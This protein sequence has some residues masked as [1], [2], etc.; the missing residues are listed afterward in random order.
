M[1]GQFT[2]KNGGNM[3][4]HSDK[5]SDKNRRPNSY[6][7]GQG[8]RGSRNQ[9][10]GLAGKAN[11]VS[12]DEVDTSK[13]NPEEKLR[14]FNKLGLLNPT[15]K[16]QLADIDAKKAKSSTANVEPVHKPSTEQPKPDV[17]PVKELSDKLGKIFANKPQLI[18][19]IVK[20][21]QSVP[22]EQLKDKAQ[23]V[24]KAMNNNTSTEPTEVF[25]TVM[26]AIEG[27]PEK[28]EDDIDFDEKEPVK[29][30]PEEG[31]IDWIRKIHK[32]VF[33]KYFNQDFDSYKSYRDLLKNKHD[34]NIF[35]DYLEKMEKNPKIKPLYDLAMNKLNDFDP[36]E[37]EDSKF[38]NIGDAVFSIIKDGENVQQS[39]GTEESDKYA[40][41]Y[42]REEE[43]SR[44]L[45]RQY[46][47][48]S[49]NDFRKDFHFLDSKDVEALIKQAKQ[50][51]NYQ[52]A[53]SAIASGVDNSTDG[54]NNE[55]LSSMYAIADDL[56]S[57]GFELKDNDNST[58]D[59][60]EYGFVMSPE[61][62][63]STGKHSYNNDPEVYQQPTLDDALVL[64]RKHAAAARK[65]DFDKFL[66]YVADGMKEQ[67][68]KPAIINRTL[69]H[70]MH[71]LKNNGFKFQS[72]LNSMVDNAEAYDPD[73]DYG[74][75]FDHNIAS[76]E[77]GMENYDKDQSKYEDQIIHV[78][79][80][81]H[82]K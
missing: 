56:G 71:E 32:F 73:D 2:D 82:G 20:A 28:D 44:D 16:Q 74:T 5:W 39:A 9:G 10:T 55:I 6:Q 76:F 79:N 21:L 26:Q 27:S 58:S 72:A 22:K 29:S 37:G 50:F 19:G 77:G 46:S 59:N 80:Q 8:S 53:L 13:M 65:E 51:K 3:A 78:Y 33:D 61:E 41:D 42:E 23:A 40:Q 70:Y 43:K 17:N 36:E 25:S 35:Q 63:S 52:S 48:M 18:Q 49:E 4:G 14:Y 68:T 31:S 45:E 47:T 15:Q 57:M 24:L 11:T 1:P 60:N 62:L 67:G 12:S 69:S 81:L 64:A 75:E 30:E 38:I 66:K 7:A 34:A 54:D